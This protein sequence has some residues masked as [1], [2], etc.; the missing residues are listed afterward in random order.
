[1]KTFEIQVSS[2]YILHTDTRG[3]VKSKTENWHL[4]LPSLGIHHLRP[5]AGWVGP[6]CLFKM[7]G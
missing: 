3:K 5:R 4:L 1:M 7:N 6:E 2:I